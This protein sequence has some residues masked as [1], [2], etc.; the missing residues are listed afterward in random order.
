MLDILKDKTRL[1]FRPAKSIWFWVVVLA[2]TAMALHMEY[3]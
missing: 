3:R 1:F 2:W